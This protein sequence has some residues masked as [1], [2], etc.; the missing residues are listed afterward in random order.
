MQHSAADRTPKRLQDS[1][2]DLWCCRITGTEVIGIEDVLQSD[3]EPNDD[4]DQQEH[5]GAEYLS[6]A[7]LAHDPSYLTPSS[8]PSAFK[9][10]FDVE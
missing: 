7:L 8:A 1:E 5:S 2:P 6:R 4:G 9:E 10:I 3:V